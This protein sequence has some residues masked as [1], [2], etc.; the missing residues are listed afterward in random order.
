M[1]QKKKNECCLPPAPPC[2]LNLEL[3][4]LVAKRGAELSHG[5]T[6][7]CHTLHSFCF[8]TIPVGRMER[9]PW[10]P[11]VPDGICLS[12]LRS[13]VVKGAN[14]ARTQHATTA[15]AAAAAAAAGAAAAAAADS[16]VEG[17]RATEKLN[18][19]GC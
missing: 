3:L 11:V 1:D 12:A 7:P 14:L 16:R 13:T 9:V 2:C 19:G 5:P 17:G 15:A 10:Q 6:S 18:L 8:S 4:C